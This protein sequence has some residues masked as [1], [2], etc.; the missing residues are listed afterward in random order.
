MQAV[1]LQNRQVGF[2]RANPSGQVNG[3]SNAFTMGAQ[4]IRI[5][6]PPH[7]DL[8]RALETIRM[9]ERAAATALN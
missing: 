6:T 1:G 9:K 3:P 7:R 8:H 4:E 5:R 2:C